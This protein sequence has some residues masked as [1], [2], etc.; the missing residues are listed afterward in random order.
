VAEQVFIRHAHA[1]SRERWDDDDRLRPLSKK[2]RRQAEAMVQ[3]LAGIAF[4]RVL[5][6]PYVRCVQTVEPLAHARGLA[7]E[8]TDALAEGA[9]LEAALGLVRELAGTPA[10]H[11]THGDIMY[12]L[13]EELVRKGLIRRGDVR[14]E[15]GSAWILDENA[16]ELVSARYVPAPRP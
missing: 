4:R 13:C 2:G 10:A 16:G 9:G 1:G 11:C 7:V 15:K 8:K 5:S 3:S 14:Y 6:S 12:E